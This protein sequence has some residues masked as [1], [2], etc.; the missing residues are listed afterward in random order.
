MKDVAEELDGDL[1]YIFVNSVSCRSELPHQILVYKQGHLNTNVC[2][3]LGVGQVLTIPRRTN[4]A[5]RQVALKGD[6]VTIKPL[7]N[8]QVVLL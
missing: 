1:A 2:S 8:L 7:H 3:L 4:V 5:V 6:A